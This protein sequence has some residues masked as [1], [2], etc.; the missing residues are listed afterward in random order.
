MKLHEI[1]DKLAREKTSKQKEIIKRSV[2]FEKRNKS[3]LR[4]TL[5]YF[6][7]MNKISQRR[8]ELRNVHKFDER[9]VCEMRVNF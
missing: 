4:H 1:N 9:K 2:M 7:T 5:G 3:P 8:G 6:L